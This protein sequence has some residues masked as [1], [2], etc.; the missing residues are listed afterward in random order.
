MQRFAPR[1]IASAGRRSGCRPVVWR[2]RWSTRPSRRY[3][4]LFSAPD[5][6]RRRRC[7]RWKKSPTR[8]AQQI[9]GAVTVLSVCRQNAHAEHEAEC[10]YKALATCNLLA[11]V[12]ALRIACGRRV[13]LQTAISTDASPCRR[14][15]RSAVSN[16][17]IPTGADGSLRPQRV[18]CRTRDKQ[19][20]PASVVQKETHRTSSGNSFRSSASVRRRGLKRAPLQ[21]LHMAEPESTG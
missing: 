5:S 9:A 16:R 17:G 6:W 12:I 1:S 19:I 2:S 20:R 13:T 8:H 11:R 4:P 3:A 10:V 21:T 15:A 14:W 18:P 7:V